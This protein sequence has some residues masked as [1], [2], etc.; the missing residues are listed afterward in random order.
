MK[1]YVEFLHSNSEGSP[2][3]KQNVRAE[4]GIP[5]IAALFFALL[6]VLFFVGLA[7]FVANIFLVGLILAVLVMLVSRVGDPGEVR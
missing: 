5:T 2:R 7:I 6:L 1:P 3:E 4:G